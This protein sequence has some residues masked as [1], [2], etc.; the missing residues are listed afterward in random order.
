VL[1]VSQLI[2][3]GRGGAPSRPAVV[4]DLAG[5]SAAAST[6]RTPAEPSAGLGA[7]GTADAGAAAILENPRIS[8]STAA[9]GDLLTRGADARLMAM[10][11]ALAAGYEV[12]VSGLPEI[13]GAP[14]D[15]PR[16]A[17]AISSV[18]GAALSSGRATEIAAWFAAQQ[19]SYRPAAVV[20][21]SGD[22]PALIVAL[23]PP[24]PAR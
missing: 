18:N 24:M 10:L 5:P 8:F 9:R 20:L 15:A 17:M 13:P 3:R 16:R 21:D 6:I 7:A 1:G 12:T 11:A 2:D 22:P 4:T 14:V 19:E 23:D